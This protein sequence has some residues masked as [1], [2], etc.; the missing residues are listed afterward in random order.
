VLK[1]TCSKV[2]IGKS[3]CDAFPI[4]NGVKQGGCGE[5]FE[6][7]TAMKMLFPSLG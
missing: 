1:E 2:C 4:Q 3:M 6:I 5:K 7:L